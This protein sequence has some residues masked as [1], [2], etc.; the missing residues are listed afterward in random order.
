[1]AVSLLSM[2]ELGGWVGE[3]GISG[4]NLAGLSRG[5]H[6]MA[7]TSPQPHLW[8]EGGVWPQVSFPDLCAVRLV[9][10]QAQCHGSEGGDPAPAEGLHATEAA[11]A[12]RAL[13]R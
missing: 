10:P 11:H 5:Q 6:G 7:M 12:R 3:T 8:W 1:M 13:S 9:W 4:L 2:W